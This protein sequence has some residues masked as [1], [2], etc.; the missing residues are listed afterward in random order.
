MEKTMSFIG[1]G[2]RGLIYAKLVKDSGRVKIT[3]LCDS[4]ENTLHGAAKELG[5]P[6]ENCFLSVCDFFAKGKLAE[7]VAIS[8]PDAVHCEQCLSAMKLGYNVLLEKPVAITEK[9]CL[10]IS[11]CAKKLGRK[12]VVC[13]VLRY[14]DF[15][16]KIKDIIDS[17]EIG[18]I[19]HISQS[20]NVGWW[21]YSQS[22][23]RGKW[24]NSNTSSPMILAKCCHDFDMINWLMGDRCTTVSSFGELSVFN[25]SHA[26]KES[27]SYCYKCELKDTCLYSAIRRSEEMPFTMN[28]PFGF[29][30]K[31]ESIRKYLEDEKNSYGKCVYRSD[32]NVVD[33]QSVI[34]QYEKG[35]TANLN[36]HAFA[37]STYRRTVVV[38]T[39]GEIVGLFDDERD[40]TI[41]VNIF[42]PVDKFAPKEYNFGEESSGHGGGD[43]GLITSFIDYMYDGK[44]NS[45]VSGIEV[46]V[47]SHQMAFAA[48]KSRLN[49]GKPVE[50]AAI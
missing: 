25:K 8:T 43:G 39:K 38:G 21:H 16:R 18:E 49:G 14:T 30:Y 47:A 31:P 27:D 24:R 46:S 11:D 6:L 19:I 15:Y 7:V 40:K 12:V 29:D 45:D 35:A 33:H 9:D 2:N 42:S 22:F 34:M 5:V 23:I 36:M 32:N 3:A 26:P 1:L 17:G 13:H 10:A 37:Q 41:S 4:D 50:I 28:V 20:E 48:E 44:Q